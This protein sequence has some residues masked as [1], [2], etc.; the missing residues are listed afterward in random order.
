MANTLTIT[1]VVT[2]V[3]GL[4]F[5]FSTIATQDTGTASAVITPAVAAPGTTRNI[6]VTMVGGA[7]PFVYSTPTAAGITFTAVAGQSNQWTFVY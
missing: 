4:T 7:A 2:D 1:G 6:T 5:P 3:T